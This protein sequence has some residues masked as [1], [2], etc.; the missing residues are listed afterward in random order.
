MSKDAGS[1]TPYR[2]LGIKLK[3]IRQKYLQ[4]ISEVSGAVEIDER[5]LDRY[6][7]GVERPDEEVLELLINH[8]NV[9]DK[10][11]ISLWSLAGYEPESLDFEDDQIDLN[12]AADLPK[13]IF[14]LLAMETKTL[15]TDALD[16]HYDSNGLL[17]N[18]KQAVG[19]QKPISVARLGMSYEQ[20]EQV[21]KTLT[22]VLLHAKYLKGPK[23]LPSPTK[24][25][26]KG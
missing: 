19:Q 11:A 22:K 21:Q 26:P 2:S 14:M 20:A 6:E 1:E 3:T 13:S 24:K 12:Q 16:I 7:A 4:S 23:A 17:L 10:D 5:D 15:Y 25:T 9:Q 8:F 18:F